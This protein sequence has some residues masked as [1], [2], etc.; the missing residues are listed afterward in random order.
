MRSDF[1]LNSIL[2]EE[3][4]RGQLCAVRTDIRSLLK[5]IEGQFQ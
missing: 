3:G 4:Q 1:S 5:R 2:Q